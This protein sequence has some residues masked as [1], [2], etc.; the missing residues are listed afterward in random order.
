[1]HGTETLRIE[2]R[3]LLGGVVAQNGDAIIESPIV[4]EGYD[5]GESADEQLA[6]S[7]MRAILVR[8]YLL[9]HFQLDASHIGMVA[10]KNVAPTGLQHSTWNGVCVVVLKQ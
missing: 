3:S 4:I 6:R 2:G 5:E 7:R 1:M 9:N 8:Q 10:M